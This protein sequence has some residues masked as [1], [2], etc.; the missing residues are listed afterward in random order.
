LLL[1]T[2]ALTA[3]ASPAYY[4]QATTGHF[5]LMQQRQPVDAIL[6]DPDADGELQD[7]LKLAGE[8]LDFAE[9]DLAL[10]TGGSYRSLVEVEGP[11]TWN[12][13]AAPEFSLQPKQWCFPV[14]GCVAYRGY[15]EREKA[16]AFARK[17]EQRGLDVAV[18]SASAYS[19][20]GWFDDPLLSTMLDQEPQRL[21]GA[22]FH[23]LAHQRLYVHDDTAFNEAYASFVESAGVE[24]W[25]GK[26]N[27]G[28]VALDAWREEQA[29]GRAFS[30]LVNEIRQ[31]LTA[32]YDSRQSEAVMRREK[33]IIF[34]DLR[35]RHGHLVRAEWG[36]RAYF[37]GWLQDGLNNA[38]LIAIGAYAGGQCAFE[39]LMS[40]SGGDFTNFHELASEVAKRPGTDRRD[41]LNQPCA[42]VASGREL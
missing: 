17:L 4:W 41:W 31:A 30:T 27:G 12:V 23:E 39:H 34:D 5:S 11:V 32:L 33:A 9:H 3:C 14:A 35:R 7:Q 18:L 8:L 6:A 28:S 22:L 38:H 42:V 19:T 21:A 20:L 10:P 36:G 16:L 26:R 1:C 13:V 15:F 24:R 29:A 2:L 37:S 25:L 40:Q